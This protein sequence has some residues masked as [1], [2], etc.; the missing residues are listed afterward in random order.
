VDEPLNFKVDTKTESSLTP[1]C[2]EVLWYWLIALIPIPCWLIPRWYVWVGAAF[3]LIGLIIWHLLRRPR[4][5]AIR[6]N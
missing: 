2:R 1:G 6:T 4:G 5:R 3:L